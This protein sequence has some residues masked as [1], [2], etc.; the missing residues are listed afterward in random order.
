MPALAMAVAGDAVKYRV[1]C[2]TGAEEDA[3]QGVLAGVQR[4]GQVDALTGPTT[5]ASSPRRRST[6]LRT[7]C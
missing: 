1:E 2:I 3:D 5:G 4:V 7:S 6:R